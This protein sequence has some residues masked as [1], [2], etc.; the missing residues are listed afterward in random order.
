MPFSP[1]SPLEVM[2]LADRERVHTSVLAW[3]LGEDSPLPVR[4]RADIIAGLGGTAPVPNPVRTSASTEVDKLDVL[5]K[6]DHQG[7]V[8][9]L[10]VEAKLRSKEGSGQ[11]A[12]YDDVISAQGLVPCAKVLLTLDGT[13]PES[14]P[15]WRPV[16]YRL[17]GEVLDQ[18]RA[19]SG[20]HDV[21]LDDF[22]RLIGRLVSLVDGLA[23]PAWT[24][25]YFASGGRDPEGAE[26][27]TSYLA[28]MKLNKVLQQCFMRRAF[29]EAVA[30]LPV[31]PG[32]EWRV[33]IEESHG[34]ALLN[35]QDTTSHPGYA[36]GIQFQHDAAKMFACPYPPRKATP[37][38][39][40]T[41]AQFLQA[42]MAGRGIDAVPTVP[43]RRGFTSV[44]VAT[45]PR[46]RDLALWAPY[47]A[48]AISVLL[49]P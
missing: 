34:H 25:A 44:R 8:Q 41:A 27:L 40:A 5:V 26:G 4:Q 24:A 47:M 49:G 32:E 18:A 21:Y 12:R 1:L 13:P 42:L 28:R 35:L 29:Q 17:L 6:L 46:T 37:Q 2:S 38:E 43:V 22:L 10:A 31:P 39:T 16:S 19:A 45:A 20:I 14:S 7:G 33:E 9:H 15:E 23:I 3:L 48:H 11:L 36:I 30:L